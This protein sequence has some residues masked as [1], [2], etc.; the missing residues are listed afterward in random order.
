MATPLHMALSHFVGWAADRRVPKSLRGPLYRTYCRITGADYGES[1]GPL[2]IYPSLGAFFVREL[3]PG[4]RPI[5]PDPLEI[6]CPVDGHF[7]TICPVH[8]GTVLQA[9][10]RSYGLREMLAGVGEDVEFEGGHAWTVY[11]SPR[12]YHRIHSP[13]DVRLSAAR[14]VDGARYSVAPKVLERRQV[15]SINERVVLRLETERGPLFLVLVGALNVGRMRV[16]GVEPSANADLGAGKPFSKG[17]ELARFEM[18][19]TIVLISPPGALEPLA[20]H[21]EGQAIRM[22]EPLA[23]WSS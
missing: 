14:W 11:L 1:R 4:A 10:G 2:E 8:K 23:R 5:S 13:E 12:D 6:A 3:L 18:G 21:A 17:A 15:L 9:K 19:S 7:Q 20:G 22:G 16:V